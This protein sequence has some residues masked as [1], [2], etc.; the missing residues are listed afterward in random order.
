MRWRQLADLAAGQ[1]GVVTLAQLLELGFSRTTVSRLAAER[2]WGRPHPGVYLLPGSA[3]TF[4]Q[5]V[6]AAQRA[7]PVSSVVTG[8]AAAHLYG[9]RPPPGVIHLLIGEHDRPIAPEGTHLTRTRT[10]LRSEI[11]VLDGITL[12]TGARMVIDYAAHHQPSEVRSLLIDARQ[13][14]L[15]DLERLEQRLQ[16]IGPVRGRGMVKRLVRE[17]RTVRA[18]SVFEDSLRGLIYRS[19]L[20]SPAPGPWPAQCGHRVLHIDIAW[21]ELM[22]GV[23]AE[24]FAFHQTRTELE[25]DHRRL[26]DLALAGWTILRVGW[27]RIETD[28]EGFID[29]LGRLISRKLEDLAHIRA[30]SSN[31]GELEAR[32]G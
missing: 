16:G 31:S 9:L 30:T 10:L 13:R 20:P 6:V 29:E 18:D 3:R 26:N 8:A 15:V 22:V 27:Q 5:R 23:E 7:L 14:R 32:R 25:R 12:A 1:H 4:A 28:P 21:P 24:G 2:G 11:T 19:G 17:Q